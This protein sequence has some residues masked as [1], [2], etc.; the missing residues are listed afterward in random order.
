MVYIDGRS[1]KAQ[2]VADTF[3]RKA[4]II[5]GD[6]STRKQGNKDMYL[7]YVGTFFNFTGQLVREKNCSDDEW[8]SL[9]LKISNPVNSH[10]VRVPFGQGYMET[11]IYISSVEQKLKSSIDRNKWD[12]VITVTYTSMKSQWLAGKTLRGV[13]Q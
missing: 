13:Y 10:V 1:Y 4:E 8:E 2:W 6:N 3:T 5:N 12:S 11:S 9:F 7:E